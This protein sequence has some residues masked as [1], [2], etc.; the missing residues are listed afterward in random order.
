MQPLGVVT[1]TD[2]QGGGGVGSDAEGLE[3]V[4]GDLADQGG[5]S[6][7][8]LGEFLIEVLDPPG[9]GPQRDLAD[10]LDVAA[11][12]GAVGGAGRDGLLDGQGPQLLP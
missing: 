2:Q 5:A 9:Q 12:V 11:G 3:Q 10:G 1:H 8:E 6:R 7:V 4:G